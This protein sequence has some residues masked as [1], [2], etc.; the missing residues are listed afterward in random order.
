[1]RTIDPNCHRA[2]SPLCASVSPLS[3]VVHHM[4]THSATARPATLNLTSLELLTPLN[5]SGAPLPGLEST[6]C[7]KPPASGRLRPGTTPGAGLRT[8]GYA[9]ARFLVHDYP[10]G[11]QGFH[12]PVRTNAGER[13]KPALGQYGELTVEQ[14]ASLAQVWLAQVRR[15]ADPAAPRPRRFLD[16]EDEYLRIRPLTSACPAA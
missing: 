5:Q 13:R 2:S 3:C 10:V 7:R 1:M 6:L 14:A 11:P 9:G 12:A 15:G 4:D 8:S 16:L